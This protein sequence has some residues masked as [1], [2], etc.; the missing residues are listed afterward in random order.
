MYI[1]F[2]INND[3]EGPISTASNISHFFNIFNE[4]LFYEPL[5]IQ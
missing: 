5:I 2:I 3:L 4:Y 1:T